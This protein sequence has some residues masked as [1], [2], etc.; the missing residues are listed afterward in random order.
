MQDLANWDQVVLWTAFVIGSFHFL[1][2]ALPKVSK[3]F[4]ALSFGQRRYV[5]KNILKSIIIITLACI[6]TQ[7]M[8]DLMWNGKADNKFIHTMGLFYAIPDLYGLHWLSPTGLLRSTTKF[9]HISVGVFALLGLFQDYSVDNYWVAMIIYAFL[10][11]WS[12]PVNFYLGFRH[13]LNREDATEDR[14]RRELARTVLWIYV[15]CCALNWLYQ[16]HVVMLWIDFRWTQLTWGTVF[17]LGAYCGIL[18]HI[19]R[20]DIDLIQS[21]ILHCKPYRRKTATIEECVEHFLRGR[22]QIYRVEEIRGNNAY[23]TLA[24]ETNETQNLVNIANEVNAYRAP[25]I[26]CAPIREFVISVGLNK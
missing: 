21:L 16:L 23:I 22:E 9:H 14:I 1:E 17:G 18:V 20:D 24:N 19:I 15:L 6:S 25:Y 8:I 4:F 11:M 3:R 5:I 2:I 10:S 13:L 12:G 7:P 26:V